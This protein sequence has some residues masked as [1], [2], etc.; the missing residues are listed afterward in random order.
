LERGRET[1]SIPVRP[2]KKKKKKEGLRKRNFGTAT[3][4]LVCTQESGLSYFNVGG[5]FQHGPLNDGPGKARRRKRRLV[6]GG[7]SPKRRGGGSKYMGGLEGKKV[8]GY[9][10]GQLVKRW[11]KP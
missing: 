9:K 2:P 11:G 5:K 7:I 10:V 1:G 6:T 8:L 4:G 3:R